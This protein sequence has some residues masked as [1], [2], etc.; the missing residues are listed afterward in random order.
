MMTDLVASQ[1]LRS[2]PLA[3]Y[4]RHLLTEAEH[5][6]AQELVTSWIGGPTL[7]QRLEALGQRLELTRD[8]VRERPAQATA[9]LIGVLQELHALAAARSDR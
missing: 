7:L 9:V 5:L 6:H 3:A 4:A 2:E 8:L 1:P